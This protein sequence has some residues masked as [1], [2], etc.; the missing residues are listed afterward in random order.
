M[1]KLLKP[2]YEELERRFQSYCRHDGGRTYDGVK[3]TICTICGWD[4]AKC[5]HRRIKPGDNF[6]CDCGEPVN[7][8]ASQ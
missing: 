8:E 5:Q 6:C 4:T 2:A 7:K 1:S 3:N